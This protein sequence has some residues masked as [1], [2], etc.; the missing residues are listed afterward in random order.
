MEKIRQKL[1]E[2]IEKYEIKAVSFD[3]FDTVIFRTTCKPQ[4]VFARMYRWRP[5]LFPKDVDAEI[6][7]CSR[8]RA[9]KFARRANE[10]SNNGEVTLADIYRKL[11]D[12]YSNRDELM[13]WEVF[14][15]KESIFLN[16]EVCAAIKSLHDAGMSVLLI[17]DMYLSAE[18]I[19][20]LL[21]E[22]GFDERTIDAVYV[23]CEYQISKRRKGLY[24]IAVNDRGILPHELLHV[25]DNYYSDIGIPEKL[26][27][28]T[29]PYM[30]RSDAYFRH[31][32]LYYEE[33]ILG[34]PIGEL[35]SMR[36]LAAQ[37]RTKETSLWYEIGAMVLG[38]L[39]AYAAEW[40][41]DQAEKEG[42]DTI[43]PFMREG[44]FLS[45]LLKQ[46]ACHRKT[47]FS[48]EPLYVS[49]IALLRSNLEKAS[50][51]DIEY[52]MSTHNMTVRSMLNIL[53]ISDLCTEYQQYFDMGTISI[54]NI[55][56]RE[57]SV[58]EEF[59][60]YLSEE[61][62]LRKIRARNQ[63]YSQ[64][65]QTYLEQM[66]MYG[67][68][69]TL[70]IGWRGS[71]QRMLHGFFE[72]RG[73]DCG[74][75][76]LL[77]FYRSDFSEDEFVWNVNSYIGR[78]GA[79]EKYGK[80]YFPRLMELFLLSTKGT[81]VGYRMEGE[82]AIPITQDIPYSDEQIAGAKELQ[83]GILSFQQVY[84]KLISAKPYL[85]KMAPMKLARS[86]ERL[87]TMPLFREAELFQVMKYD[88]NFGANTMTPVIRPEGLAKRKRKGETYYY[89]R[90]HAQEV[91]WNSGMNVL[92][93]PAFYIRKAAPFLLYAG[94]AHMLV[95]EQALLYAKDASIV[96]IG[97]GDGGN[98]VLQAAAVLG[99]LGR[100]EKIVDN[101]A[102]VWGSFIGGVPVVKPD[103]SLKGTICICS[104]MDY[105]ICQQII[106]QI[107]KLTDGSVKI[108]HFFEDES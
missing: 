57:K 50:R 2:A 1:E 25:G 17:S 102:A 26:G 38:P 89:S 49:R 74:L 60:D 15:E 105:V 72:H 34:N 61:S 75:K 104:I 41:L 39:F 87:L 92:A 78:Y 62:V 100:I 64:S 5:E 24:E 88:Q 44:E 91:T 108:F 16:P 79:E 99:S 59:L 54:K 45:S 73:I 33:E 19:R 30:L 70:D 106:T 11:P 40:V 81:T 18:T 43:R 68:A 82:N 90:S 66:G 65:F 98:K 94:Y 51:K 86:V 101:N 32:F 46:A 47:N 9:E 58:Y 48:I 8:V 71:M 36:L 10:H 96:L 3:I 23:S 27:I 31:P 77:F 67:N 83:E 28:H 13:K 97:A 85:E 69:I 42:I 55:A 53:M 37:N 80:T 4:D 21:R 107:T 29:F 95:L 63:T 56:G 52:L 35:L 84:Y 76:H 7:K 6:W 14:C 22:N 20:M 93:D 103:A 12:L